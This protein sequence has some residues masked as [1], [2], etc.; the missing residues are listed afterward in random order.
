[1]NTEGIFASIRTSLTGLMSQSR[2][3]EIIAENIANA[4][5]PADKN[6]EIYKKKVLKTT[7]ETPDFE[8]TLQKQFSLGLKSTSGKHIHSS[9][10][11]TG[12]DSPIIP[13]KLAE[14]EIE[15]LNS[16]KSVYN[17]GHPMADEN[18]FVRMPDIN[19][20]EEMVDMISASR[21]YEANLTVMNAAKQIARDTMK[22]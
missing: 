16:E 13:Q 19:V 17:P 11:A 8:K 12:V 6:G 15:E 22:I 21:A 9:A 5:K 14:I 10:Q 4:E 3:L 20:V 7:A 2:N 18:G 1:M